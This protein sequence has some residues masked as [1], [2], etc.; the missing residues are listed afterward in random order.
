MLTNNLTHIKGRLRATATMAAFCG[1][2]ILA[3]LA[4][5]CWLSAALFIWLLESY[6]PLAASVVMGAAWVIVAGLLAFAGWLVRR[7]Q[8]QKLAM[9]ERSRPVK[10]WVNP[11]TLAAGLDMAQMVGGRRASALV[12]GAFAVVWL[13]GRLGQGATRADTSDDDAA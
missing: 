2:A 12:V 3:A 1:A 4:A 8:R 13:L 9:M 10:T 5:V 11:S 6:T 7:S